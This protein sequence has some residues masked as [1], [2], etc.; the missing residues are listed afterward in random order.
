MSVIILKKNGT[1][2]LINYN[3][4]LGKQVC[5]SFDIYNKILYGFIVSTLISPN[6][7]EDPYAEI[8]ITITI[9]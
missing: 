6:I 1:Q 4:T 8:S 7:I 9:K 3:S 5:T 2:V